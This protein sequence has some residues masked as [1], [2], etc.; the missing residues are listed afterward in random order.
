M[1]LDHARGPHGRLGGG[2]ARGA[3]RS[4]RRRAAEA[5]RVRGVDEIHG[6]SARV[7]PVCDRIATRR[8]ERS[9][10]KTDDGT[11]AHEIPVAK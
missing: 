8:E 11:G 5:H 3:R 1:H 4:D 7:G 10:K 2:A 9:A 6:R